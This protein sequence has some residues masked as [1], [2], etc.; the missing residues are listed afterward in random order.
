[1]THEEKI[2]K[3]TKKNFQDRFNTKT[4]MDE[5]PFKIGYGSSSH[6]PERKGGITTCD[7]KLWCKFLERD[8]FVPY[9][10]F[11]MGQIEDMLQICS[12]DDQVISLIEM[13]SIKH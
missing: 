2:E 8:W 6:H 12:S 10:N 4:P 11:T 5:M 3:F 1:M 9:G 7:I 13:L